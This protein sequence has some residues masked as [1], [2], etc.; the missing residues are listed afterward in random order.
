[1]SRSIQFD[2]HEEKHIKQLWRIVGEIG[3]EKGGRV[4]LGTAGAFIIETV[5]DDPELLKR[6]M[7]RVSEARIHAASESV[8]D[9][10]R[11]RKVHG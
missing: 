10:L 9:A 5:L 1:M 11:R 7:A 2:M 3:T 6:V 4:G 8:E